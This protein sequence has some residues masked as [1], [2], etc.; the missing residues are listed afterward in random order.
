[1]NLILRLLQVLLGSRRRGRMDV[2]A[3]GRVTLRCWPN[4]L[5][6]NLHMNNGRYLTIM[7]LGRLDLILRTG[8]LP[9]MR[10]RKWYPVIATAR[11]GFR[12]SINVFDRFDLTTRVIGWDEK[13]LYIEH[14]MERGD[15]VMAQAFVKGLFLGPDGKVPMAELIAAAGHQGLSPEIDPEILAALA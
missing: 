9:V 15:K 11:I 2:L 5:D 8:L 7:D 14:R 6:T 1:M 10:S 12:R 13:W 4:D 3:E